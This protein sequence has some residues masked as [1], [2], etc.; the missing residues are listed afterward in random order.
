MNS[1]NWALPLLFRGVQVQN[2]AMV[3]R[4]R[5][6]AGDAGIVYCL[7][8]KSVEQ[9]AEFLVAQGIPALPVLV[10]MCSNAP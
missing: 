2:Q 10:W 8:R 7:S 9:T 3:D 5:Q 6:H 4:F 1:L